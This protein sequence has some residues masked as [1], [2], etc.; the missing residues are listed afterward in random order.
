[1]TTMPVPKGFYVTSGFGPRWGALHAGT[2]FGRDGGSGGHPV[3]A[4]RAGTVLYAGAADGYGGPDP[5]GWIV[6]DHP[7]ED[8]GGTSE[9]GHL[10]REVAVG[11]H[12]AEGQRIGRINPDQNTNGGV[13]PHCHFSWM[14]YDYNPAAKQD[15][16]TT[17]LKGARWPGDNPTPPKEPAVNHPVLD[18]T[19]RFSFGNPR[20][21]SAISGIC[22][23]VTVNSP[24]SPAEGV[25]NYQINSESG[26]YHELVDTRPVVLVENTDDWVTWSAGQTSNYRHLHRSFVMRGSE[27]DA[28]W[29]RYD[30]MLRAGAQRDAAWAKRYNIPIVK[31][32]AA[33]LRAGKRGFFGH[34][35]TAAAWGETDHTDPGEGFPWPYYL[36]LVREYQ[37]GTAAPTPGGI[38]VSEADRIIDFIKGFVAP[39][40]SDVKDVRQQATGGRDAGQYP[41]WPQLGQNAKGQN[42]TLVDAIAALRRDVADLAKRLD[43]K[44]L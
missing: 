28:E 29:R 37:S 39:I 6:I 43:A 3:Y 17:V 21:T 11:A 4:V 40:G 35:D 32:S 19:D 14:P 42:L 24:G 23:H 2:D 10:I 38:T 30:A 8:G 33:D 34:S 44:G 41:G 31:L 26:S 25:A 15:P 12:V 16:M 22:I 5:C 1:M 36:Q 18:W 7:A 9:Y 13:A 27:S 20:P